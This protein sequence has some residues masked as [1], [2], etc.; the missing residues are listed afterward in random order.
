MFNFGAFAGGL[1][2]GIRSGEEMEI[3]RRAGDR[4]AK[5]D[6]REAG[7]HQARMNRARFNQD[8][9]ERLQAANEEIV[10]GW[11]PEEEQATAT[12]AETNPEGSGTAA[13]NF[14][15]SVEASPS[16]SLAQG[17]FMTG[18]LQPKFPDAASALPA[19]SAASGRAPARSTYPSPASLDGPASAGLMSRY[20]STGGSQPPGAAPADEMIARRMLTGNL[21]E[22]ADEL[23]RMAN[24]YRKH[25]LVG[26]MTP[27][28]NKAWEAKKKRIPD[29][30]HFLL[31][32]DAKAAR[33]ALEKGGIKLMDD[34]V[35]IQQND[36]GTVRCQ[37]RLEDGNTQDIDLKE[38]AGRFFPSST[39]NSH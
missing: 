13:G 17:S 35:A 12:P 10:N 33:R 26:E 4:L 9:L 15:E 20:K 22:D 19:T 30:L 8:K 16:P 6:E 34:P 37:L 3:R 5:A 38:L 23:T 24:I 32:G 31:R 7:L 14:G 18:G 2:Q 11:K 27:W 21:L 25:G 29:A 36:P 39:L 1:A 28:M